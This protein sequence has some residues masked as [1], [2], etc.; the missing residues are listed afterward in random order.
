MPVLRPLAFD[1]ERGEGVSLDYIR[2]NYG[3]P[4]KR[5]GRVRL[6]YP[7]GR[8]VT[9]QITGTHGAHLRV[10]AQTGRPRVLY[11]HPTWRVTYL[12]HDTPETTDCETA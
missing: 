6:D 3:V 7:N 5:G 4:A 9:G 12:D 8:S 11:L 2:K 10:L 1:E